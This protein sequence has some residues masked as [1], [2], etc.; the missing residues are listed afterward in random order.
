M[1]EWGFM[2]SAS[3]A[4]DTW[5]AVLMSPE[6]RVAYAA[7]ASR[8]RAGGLKIV[9]SPLWGRFALD[10]TSCMVTVEREHFTQMHT[11]RSRLLATEAQ[12]MTPLWLAAA[13]RG[14][15]ILALLP[16]GTLAGIKAGA[17]NQADLWG[18]RLDELADH[19]GLLTGFATVLD[20]PAPAAGSG[21]AQIRM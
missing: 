13:R 7:L 17:E 20:V 2:V 15:V 19:G 10:A 6:D 21:T 9:K 18:A 8:L 16:P 4:G 3:T 11:G 1:I 14:R 5:A 12:P